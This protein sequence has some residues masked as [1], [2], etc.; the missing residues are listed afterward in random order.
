M[1]VSPAGLLPPPPCDRSSVTGVGR[2]EGGWTASKGREE[3]GCCV[4]PRLPTPEVLHTLPGGSRTLRVCAWPTVVSEFGDPGGRKEERPTLRAAAQLLSLPQLSR[5]DRQGRRRVNSLPWGGSSA[6]ARWTGITDDGVVSTR[7]QLHGKK[8]KCVWGAVGP[9]GWL[10][11]WLSKV[12]GNR[13]EP[14]RPWLCSV[15]LDALGDKRS[16][17][18]SG[19]VAFSLFTGASSHWWR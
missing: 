17:K 14:R 16:Q 12:D 5:E 1:P 2:E 3:L 18:D 15:T 13:L 10:A 9:G 7:A 6:W 11:E 4:S 8:R 19:E